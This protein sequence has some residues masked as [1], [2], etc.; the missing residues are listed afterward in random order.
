MEMNCSFPSLF[1]ELRRSWCQ[2]HRKS[3]RNPL[4]SLP[5][6]YDEEKKQTFEI[7]YIF[8]FLMIFQTLR[9]SKPFNSLRWA[10]DSY[11]FPE[12]A[13]KFDGHCG[14]LS[15]PRGDGRSSRIICLRHKLILY[16]LSYGYRT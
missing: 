3:I 4:A 6:R 10:Q 8:H 13:I 16:S 1:S 12:K 2:F 9:G 5:S 11:L 7:L 15:S 14:V